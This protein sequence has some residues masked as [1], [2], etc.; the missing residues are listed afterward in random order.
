[1]PEPSLDRRARAALPGQPQR[2][3][4]RDGRAITA[5]A[6][7]AR[8]GPHQDRIGRFEG[9]GATNCTIIC[10]GGKSLP[11]ETFGR[12]PPTRVPL[13]EID[14]A[15]RLPATLRINCETFV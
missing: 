13:N 8:T 10:N 3:P 11:P 5:N 12:A 15:P 2:S 7:S 4:G 1:M 14:K 9:S 6:K